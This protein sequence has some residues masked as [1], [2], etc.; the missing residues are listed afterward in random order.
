MLPDASA[1]RPDADVELEVIAR[2]PVACRHASYADAHRLDAL[3]RAWRDGSEMGGFGR[4][5]AH[6]SWRALAYAEGGSGATVAAFISAQQIAFARTA[7]DLRID[8]VS[9]R[10]DRD[11]VRL[12]ADRI[13]TSRGPFR[14]LRRA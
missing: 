6:G 2:R 4:A 13:E 11:L 5:Q 8:V 12:F 7:L 1:A 9:V 10:L 3:L 14:A